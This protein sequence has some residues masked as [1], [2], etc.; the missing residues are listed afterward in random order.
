MLLKTH[1]LRTLGRDALWCEIF[2]IYSGPSSIQEQDGV[3][4]DVHVQVAPYTISSIQSS[5]LLIKPIPRYFA[6]TV[7]PFIPKCSIVFTSSF[8]YFCTQ[9]T[10]SQEILFATRLCIIGPRALALG[11]EQFVYQLI[12]FKFVER[13]KVLTIRRCEIFKQNAYKQDWSNEENY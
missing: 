13:K 5:V 2:S 7:D 12:F 4:I 10:V 11:K 3:G 1:V 8:I 9:L 6:Y